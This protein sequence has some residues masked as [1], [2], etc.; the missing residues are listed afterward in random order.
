MAYEELMSQAS[1]FNIECF[2]G[3]ENHWNGLGMVSE[4]KTIQNH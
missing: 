3:L 4:H 1:Q 2:Q